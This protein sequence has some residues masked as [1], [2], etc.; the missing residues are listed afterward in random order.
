MNESIIVL[1]G[2]TGD[3][4]KR[5]IIPAIYKLLLTKKISKF[6][7]VGAALEDIAIETIL[8]R[9]KPYC[10][11]IEDAV[12]NQLVA[13][14]SY[15]PVNFNQPSDFDAL[16]KKLDDISRHQNLTNR[17]IYFAIPASFYCAVTEHVARTGIAQ[18][19]AEKADH[20]NRLV[21][22]KP[23]GYDLA[24]ARK[25]NICIAH[26]FNENQ[27]YR[28]DHYLTKELVSNIA[29]VRFTNCVLE[30]LWNHRFID[31]VQIILNETETIEDRGLYYD[32]AGALRD[33]VQNH[34]L[35]MLAL[36]AME[37]P[38]R[39]TGDYIRMQRAQVLKNV[40][41]DDILLGQYEGYAQEKYV[42][43]DSKTETFVVARLH[44]N[45]QR[46]HGVPFYFKTGKAL[47]KKS[48]SIHI[49]F[50]QVDCLLTRHCFNDSNYLTIEI[51]P[52]GSIS[53][54]LNAKKV[55][56]SDEV[57]PVKMEF[58]HSCLF[59][60][61]TPDAYETL[62]EEIMKGEHSV[63]VRNDEIEY[64]WNITDAMHALPTK[65]YSYIK[66]SS[67]PEELETFNKKHGIRWRA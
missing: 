53:L 31:Q 12:W 64:A 63:S 57:A 52:R 29:L 27:I 67:G 62:L 38:E 30:P 59:G 47:E 10:S 22:E 4:A 51:S 66:G 41:V 39:L 50:K 40:S 18:K 1:F 15:V 6:A 23:F 26:H 8:E 21:Y 34:M 36:V 48:T 32:H 60:P 17:L 35:E 43:P 7:L 42:M 11:N 20:W 44:I 28:I 25:I 13:S 9:A 2:A 54:T 55:G 3:L 65:V 24:S 56:S 5:K 16:A 46:W 61:L 19:V 14:S 37:T 45:N 33:V 58:C 49:K